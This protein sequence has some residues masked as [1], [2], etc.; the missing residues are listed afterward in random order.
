MAEINSIEFNFKDNI[1]HCNRTDIAMTIPPHELVIVTNIYV[2]K[3]FLVWAE[4]SAMCCLSIILIV[5]HL[6]R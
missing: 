4:Q 6:E 2:L 3:L 1:L 5:G